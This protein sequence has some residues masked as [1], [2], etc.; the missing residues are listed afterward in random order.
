MLAVCCQRREH[1]RAT[2][3]FFPVTYRK[4]FPLHVPT[5]PFRCII[6]LQPERK[7]DTRGAFRGPAA[8]IDKRGSGKPR[9]GKA[10]CN[11]QQREGPIR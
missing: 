1:F 2:P 8:G 5:R 11:C 4:T 9:S 6:P 3:P 7:G 10:S